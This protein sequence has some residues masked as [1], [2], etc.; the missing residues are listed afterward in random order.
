MSAN[1]PARHYDVSQ[2]PGIKGTP[3][4][5]VY[6][7]IAE[8]VGSGVSDSSTRMRFTPVE[9]E[10]MQAAQW[11]H[12]KAG[13]SQ[14]GEHKTMEDVRKGL[15][16]SLDNLKSQLSR[17][18]KT[19]QFKGET[20][21]AFFNE[22]SGIGTGVDPGSWNNATIPIS[23]SPQEATAYYSNG[24]IAAEIEDKKGRGIF[25]NDYQF[26]GDEWDEGDLKKLKEHADARNFRSEA[27]DWWTWGHV[28]GGAL[29]VP[30]LDGDSP[31]TYLMDEKQLAR[32]GMLK[33]DCVQRFWVTDRWNSVLI[34]DYNISAADYITPKEFT[35]PIAGLSVSTWRMALGRPKKLP[36]WG[37]LR[38]MGWA[39]SDF[40]SFMPSLLAYELGTKSIPAISQS[41]SLIYLEAPLDAIISQAGLNAARQIKNDNE[42]ALREWSMLNPKLINLFGNLK[43]IDRH[44]TDF[45]DLILL[46]KQDVG[47]K[48][49]FSHTIIFNELQTGMDQKSYDITLKQTETI[50][51][52]GR[53]AA[54]QLQ[55]VVRMLVYSCFGYGSPQ[56]QKADKVHIEFDIPVIPTNEEMAEML[57]AAANGVNGFMQ[58]GVS[59]E[60]ALDLTR[61]FIPKL[62]ISEDL[63]ERIKA[64]VMDKEE[65]ADIDGAAKK[66][67]LFDSWPG[68]RRRK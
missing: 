46:L 27:E 64:I 34:P 38:Q 6:R 62:E 11:E 60:D 29:M 56:A 3:M 67:G 39:I 4:E 45:K 63:R 2:A 68:L 22:V 19:P 47:A 18:P 28:Y 61:Q 49:G 44:F 15:E 42:K 17:G 53:T 35:I 24:G 65:D 5:G 48:S 37:T 52:S 66:A 25:M 36:Y 58:A 21:D 31:L 16:V 8:K 13:M 30:A 26:A 54:L 10:D 32:Q 40:V 12:V 23:I 7:K 14:L 1:I 20:I 55:P 43:S 51:R 33:K 59:L 57:T 50:R 41:L 9:V